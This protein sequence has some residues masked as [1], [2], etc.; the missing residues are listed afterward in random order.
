LSESMKA[1]CVLLVV[2]ALVFQVNSQASPSN[3]ASLAPSVSV[4]S[5]W[6]VTG[7]VT[8]TGTN[9]GTNSL[10]PTVSITPTRPPSVSNTRS[11]APSTSNSWTPSTSATSTFP[12][13]PAPVGLTNVCPN[14]I[15]N[16]CP[17]WSDPTGIIFDSYI[18]TYV[19]TGTVSPIFTITLTP[20][21][22]R[23]TALLPATSYDFTVQG[24]LNGVASLS[25]TVLTV[26]TA[27]A[28]PKLDKTRDISNIACTNVKSTVTNRSVIL[29]TWGAALDTV[30]ELRIKARCTSTIREPDEVRKHLFGSKAT[31]TT[32]TLNMNR[33]VAVCEVFFRARYAR[34]RASRHHLT[35]I[36]GQ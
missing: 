30:V 6:T 21:S 15:V 31:A 13:P 7:T 12:P 17:S 27:A 35:V 26:V 11:S 19:V 20:T 36:M 8:V 33:D 14:H 10:T 24:V 22:G 1:F 4:T 9:S 34:R 16:A 23:V 25:S 32:V 29:C 2:L 28:D 3:S 18:L 5:T